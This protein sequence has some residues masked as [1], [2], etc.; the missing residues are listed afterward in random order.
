MDLWAWWFFRV[1]EG[2]TKIKDIYRESF[3]RFK[4]YFELKYVTVSYHYRI[5]PRQ[6][7]NDYSYNEVDEMYKMILFIK[8]KAG[9][10]DKWVHTK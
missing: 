3:K 10:E 7:K 5:P 9:E 4:T 2:C 1:E 6:L 8:S